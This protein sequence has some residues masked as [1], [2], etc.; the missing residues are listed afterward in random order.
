MTLLYTFISLAGIWYLA[1]TNPKRRR[2]FDQPILNRRKWVWVARLSILVPGIMLIFAANWSG[3]SIWAGAITVAGWII[4]AT[5]PVHL[6]RI[7]TVGQ[8]GVLEARVWVSDGWFSLT[9]GPDTTLG[10]IRRW[11]SDK[12]SNSTEKSMRIEELEARVAELEAELS[13][14]KS[15]KASKKQRSP[16]LKVIPE[17]SGNHSHI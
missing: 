14:K 16:S 9:Q 2:T 6:D 1:D 15:S 5:S 3:L 11:L 13:D 8:C 4:A 7:K 10:S 17:K 12:L